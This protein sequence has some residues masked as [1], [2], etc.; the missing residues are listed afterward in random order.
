MQLAQAAR[1]FVGFV[2]TSC[3]F[4][5]SGYGGTE[6]PNH[7]AFVQGIHSLQRAVAGNASLNSRHM[8]RLAEQV[9]GLTKSGAFPEQKWALDEPAQLSRELDRSQGLC[10]FRADP[11]CGG[12][13]IGHPRAI[14]G[15]IASLALREASRATVWI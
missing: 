7:I 11:T 14:G 8:Q 10:L 5:T 15:T 4:A 6:D 13:T 12:A 3:R 9:A 1:G 2:A